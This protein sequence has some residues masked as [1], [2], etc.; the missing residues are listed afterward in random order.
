MK[1]KQRRESEVDTY[2][3]SG[4]KIKREQ[5]GETVDQKSREGRERRTN[6]AEKTLSNSLIKAPLS[7][8]VATENP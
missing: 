7:H 4:K 3:I 8:L 6:M 5:E 2:A 1:A